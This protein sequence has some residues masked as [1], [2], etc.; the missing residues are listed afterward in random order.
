MWEDALRG[1]RRELEAARERPDALAER[2][3]L[4]RAAV[5]RR[6]VRPEDDLRDEADARREEVLARPVEALRDR[7]VVEAEARDLRRLVVHSTQRQS[8]L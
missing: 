4:E 3:E 7:R 5:E 2:R 6:V 1:G 8:A